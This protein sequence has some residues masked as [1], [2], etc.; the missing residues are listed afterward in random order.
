MN[1]IK[2]LGN[3]FIWLGI[4]LS[5]AGERKNWFL[6]KVC[7]HIGKGSKLLGY[8]FGA[9]PYLLWIGDNVI[10]AVG[11][12]FIEHDA[13]YFNVYR[14][15]GKKFIGTGGKM[16]GIIVRN[17]VF[18]GAGSI[19][20]GGADIGENSIIAAGSIVNKKIPPNE[21][22]GGTPAHFIMS[23][24]EYA[25]KV[26]KLEEKLPWIQSGEYKDITEKELM[27]KR[28]NYYLKSILEEYL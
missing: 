1:L 10:A 28:Q 14:Y 21:V 24:D 13:S 3:K 4:Y 19:I 9:E 22:W 17:N 27:K 7:C 20:F 2:K 11:T 8:Q 5:P 12:S 15:L 6:R 23:I 16:G 26:V 25:E 18:I